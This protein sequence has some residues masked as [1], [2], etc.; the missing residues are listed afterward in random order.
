MHPHLI[1]VALGN[2]KEG[3]CCA[4]F[5]AE[6]T[7]AFGVWRTWRLARAGKVRTLY[8]TSFVQ[9]LLGYPHQAYLLPNSPAVLWSEQERSQ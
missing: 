6:E 5:T 9:N 1:L 4:R 2:Q 3:G 8:L 7:E